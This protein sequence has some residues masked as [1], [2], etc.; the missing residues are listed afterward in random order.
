MS[1]TIDLDRKKELEA[2]AEAA[3]FSLSRVVCE[4]IDDFFTLR[5]ARIIQYLR[6]QAYR[7]GKT[8]DP[9]DATPKEIMATIIY[10]IEQEM[11]GTKGA[12]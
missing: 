4:I 6:Q 2:M 7:L 10:M 1:I 11:L 8:S 5:N 9:R 12:E 3:G